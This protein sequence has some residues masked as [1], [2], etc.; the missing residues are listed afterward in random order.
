M[1]DEA[2]EGMTWFLRPGANMAV[3]TGA[4]L[5]DA[6]SLTLDRDLVE[7]TGVWPGKR[8]LVAR[9]TYGASL[10]ICLTGR[11]RCSGTVIRN[12]AAP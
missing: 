3:V 8:V 7:R 1:F 6:S 11:D 4:G 5:E 2:A 12:T 9:S 10:E